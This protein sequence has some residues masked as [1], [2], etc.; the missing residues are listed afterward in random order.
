MTNTP[1]TS[2]SF[3]D[4]RWPQLPLDNADL[5]G[6]VDPTTPDQPSTNDL[7]IG[8]RKIDRG[9]SFLAWTTYRSV[10][11]LIGRHV[12]AD[13]GVAGAP[14]GFVDLAKKISRVRGITQR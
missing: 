7:L 14:S 8:L 1:T 12:D 4:S 11:E 6:G 3:T 5:L 10:V 9:R 2:L 13:R